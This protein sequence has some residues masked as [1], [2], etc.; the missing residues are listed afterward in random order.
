M[1][2]PVYGALEAVQHMRVGLCLQ[3]P[4]SHLLE[5]LWFTGRQIVVL[6]HC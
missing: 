2:K 3:I 6:A 5:S 1:K 4:A